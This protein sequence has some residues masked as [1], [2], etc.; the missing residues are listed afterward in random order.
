MLSSESGYRTGFRH[1]ACF[2]FGAYGYLAQSISLSCVAI[3]RPCERT[4]LLPVRWVASATP[5]QP[6][7]QRR[8]L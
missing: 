1:K 5:Q 7:R 8:L 6:A 4:R 2:L 3:V